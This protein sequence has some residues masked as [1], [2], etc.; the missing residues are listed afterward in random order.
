[1][2]LSLVAKGFTTPCYFEGSARGKDR[3]ISPNTRSKWSSFCFNN[4]I[5]TI[6]YYHNSSWLNAGNPDKAVRNAFVYELDKYLKVI[7]SI[8]K[9]KVR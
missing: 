1:M 2:L 8:T 9:M 3:R 4:E 6:Q 7:T 5:N